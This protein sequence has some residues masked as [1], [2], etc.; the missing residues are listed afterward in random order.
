MVAATMPSFTSD[1]AKW[2]GFRGD[3]DVAGGGETHAAT[4]CVALHARDHRPRAGMH[5]CEHARHLERVGMIVGVAE[6][7]HRPHPVEIGA[8][9]ERRARAR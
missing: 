3:D 6:A 5:G 7:R 4:E 9:A 2:R 8:G 1:N